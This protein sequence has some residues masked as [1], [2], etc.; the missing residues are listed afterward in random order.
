VDEGR[1]SVGDGRISRSGARVLIS[2]ALTAGADRV[3]SV[4]EAA[5]LAD[6]LQRETGN[7]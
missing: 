5:L 6:S 2:P 1:S 4:L 3:R 7:A